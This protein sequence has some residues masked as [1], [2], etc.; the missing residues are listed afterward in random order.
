MSWTRQ[1]AHWR[2]P[3]DCHDKLF[4][5]VASAGQ[6]L[7]REHW[8]MVGAVRIGFLP[9]TDGV[10]NRLRAAWT[11][12][13]FHHPDI[14]IKL[15][16][17]EKRYEPIASAEELQAWVAATFHVETTA[18]SA[19][20]LFSRHLKVASANATCHWLPASDEI[21]I[22]SSHWRWD[23]RG[24]MMMLGE[25]LLG[26]AAHDPQPTSS[27]FGDE[28]YNLVPSLDALIGMPD[29]YEAMWLH[30]AEKL[31]APLQQGT[32]S[33]GLP[34]ATGEQLPGDTRRIETVVTHDATEALRAA[35]RARHI[36]LTAALHASIIVETARYQQSNYNT[37]T[38]Y[39]SWA[40]FDVRKYCPAPFDGPSYSPALRVVV[41]P[42]VAD[43]SADW[44]A[45]A[46]SIQ[47]LYQQSFSPADNDM[48]F[49]R[50]PYYEQVMT[51][52]KTAT[53]TTEPNLSNLGVL[54]EYVK[55]QYGD[56]TVH[57]V[58]L[59]VQM[60]SAQLYLHT[61]SW[62]GQL[63]I[64]ICYNEAFYEATFVKKW[65]NDLRLNLFKNLEVEDTESDE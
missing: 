11:A 2:R 65:L 61:W 44:N 31:L 25:F 60:L 17:D 36:R 64:S 46:A 58:Q 23:G 45:L 50:V 14:A 28:A 62:N 42:L 43:A 6:S 20:A 15:R 29:K 26:L 3:L 35:C 52:L 54:D 8:L 10:E 24:M 5:S 37:T 1:G 19:D 57:N 13:R 32:P 22:V 33:I 59:A 63:H 48:L 12:L 7:G 47:P 55:T 18:S 51:M 53:P 56:V 9:G 41:L 40:A 4:Q 34:V 30:Q 16:S 39:K 21:A 27:S 38:L 49:V